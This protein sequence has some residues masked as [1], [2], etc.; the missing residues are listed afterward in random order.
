[1]FRFCLS[2][3]FFDRQGGWRLFR[4]DRRHG[5][6]AWVRVLGVGKGWSPAVGDP[7]TVTVETISP[8]MFDD[9]VPTTARVF[10]SV[11]SPQDMGF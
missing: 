8:T 3:Q 9:V 1:M 7:I 2:R 10:E 6:V 4:R 11:T 5:V